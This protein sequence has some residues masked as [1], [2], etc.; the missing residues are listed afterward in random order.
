MDWQ[1]RYLSG[2]TPWDKGA[3]APSLLPLFE[4]KPELFSGQRVFVPGCGIGYDAK[5]LAEYGLDV[6]GGDIAPLA[7]ARAKELNPHDVDFRELNIFK[8]PEGLI[9]SFDMVWEHTCFCALDPMHRADYVAAMWE[10]LKPNGLVLG[11]FFTNPDVI[12]NEGPPYKTSR[13]ELREIFSSHFSL[14]WVAAPKAFYQGR[15]GREHLMLF[16]KL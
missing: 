5:E 15:E 16:K 2:D 10:L 6:V 11:V 1:K 13:K 3:S 8:I 9:G 14:E 12:P 7:I 4:E